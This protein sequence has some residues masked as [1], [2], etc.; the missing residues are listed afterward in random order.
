MFE[1]NGPFFRLYASEEDNDSNHNIQIKFSSN[2]LKLWL[3]IMLAFH[4]TCSPKML[5]LVPLLI[6]S[7]CELSQ[8]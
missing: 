8:R 7:E 5:L 1:V 4:G 3:F 2:G 6:I